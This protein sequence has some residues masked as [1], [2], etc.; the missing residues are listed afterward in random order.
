MIT[1]ILYAWANDEDRDIVPRESGQ[2]SRDSIFLV[3]R[4]VA[5]IPDPG[6]VI[7]QARVPFHRVVLEGM[8]FVI[9]S[10]IAEIDA[11][12]KRHLLINDH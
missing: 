12:N 1:H 6:I 8:L 2:I 3:L 10:A 4:Q 5:E 7:L 11:T 9:E